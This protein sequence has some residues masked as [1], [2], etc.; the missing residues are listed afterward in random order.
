MYFRENDI[1]ESKAILDKIP[2]E[3][4]VVSS[5]SS[6]FSLFLDILTFKIKVEV[7]LQ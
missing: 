4:P 3:I 6:D 2:L 7:H 1:T 5:P